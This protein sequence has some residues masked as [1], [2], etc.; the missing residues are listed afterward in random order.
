MVQAWEPALFRPCQSVGPFWGFRG[1]WFVKNWSLSLKQSSH[2][3]SQHLLALSLLLL[4]LVLLFLLLQ[5]QLLHSLEQRI[6]CRC[7]C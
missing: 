4:L 3:L 7:R 2:H 5:Q 1:F 6:C